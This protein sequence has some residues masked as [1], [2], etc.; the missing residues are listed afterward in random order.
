MSSSESHIA[1]NAAALYYKTD[2]SIGE[3]KKYVDVTLLYPFINTTGEYPVG[4]PE[5]ITH[6]DTTDITR[7]FGVAK[8]DMRYFL[9]M[10]NNG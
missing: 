10:P 7:F 1:T 6:S 8:V 4:H 9:T 3:E 5:I 2:T